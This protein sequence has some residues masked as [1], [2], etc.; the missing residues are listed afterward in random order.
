VFKIWGQSPTFV[1]CGKQDNP[2]EYVGIIVVGWFLGDVT[3]SH[4]HW[5]NVSACN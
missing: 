1:L 2:K 5:V 4:D 3:L